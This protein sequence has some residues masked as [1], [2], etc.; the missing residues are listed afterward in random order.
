MGERLGSV[1]CLKCVHLKINSPSGFQ[2][3]FGCLEQDL[4][5]YCD[6]QLIHYGETSATHS[7]EF[8]SMAVSAHT[9][10]KCIT[11]TS[12]GL[13]L[14]TFMAGGEDEGVTESGLPTALLVYAQ[15]AVWD[16]N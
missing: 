6:W 12:G 3:E 14:L 13:Q 5:Q 11:F 4:W 8:R 7:D 15:A 1:G 2:L 9:D 10:P 16:L